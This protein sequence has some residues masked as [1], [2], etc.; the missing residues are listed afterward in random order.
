MPVF[1]IKRLRVVGA[2]IDRGEP[3][4]PSYGPYIAP[5]NPGYLAFVV[6][7]TNRRPTPVVSVPPA[8]ID[9]SYRGG[10]VDYIDGGVT[11]VIVHDDVSIR[12]NVRG[13]LPGTLPSPETPVTLAI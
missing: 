10:G 3:D 13:T 12:I 8:R 9:V 5:Q 11:I 2:E 4:Q 1:E 6:L 7:R